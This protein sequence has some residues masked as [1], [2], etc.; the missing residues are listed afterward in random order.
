[1]PGTMQ[2]AGLN[3]G[4]GCRW[5]VPIAK[6]QHGK[7]SALE[8]LLYN[9]KVAE[10]GNSALL[11]RDPVFLRDRCRDKCRSAQGDKNS[12]SRAVAT[13]STELGSDRGR[14]GS[15]MVQVEE[16]RRDEIISKQATIGLW[17]GVQTVL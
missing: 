17:K 1:M 14:S 15:S 4:D 8:Q 7:N 12:N 9:R 2:V 6:M 10:R 16:F 5:S 3:A 13:T 11:G